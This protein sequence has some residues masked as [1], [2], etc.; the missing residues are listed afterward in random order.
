MKKAVLL[1][2]KKVD[3]VKENVA[4]S[5]Y[6][7]TCQAADGGEIFEIVSSGAFSGTAVFYKDVAA[8]EEI[9]PGRVAD[10]ATKAYLGSTTLASVK[11][12]KATA[13]ALAELEF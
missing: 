6:V 13:T 1:F 7:G 3:F 11:E 8:G 2:S 5:I 12:I 10:V 4:R 9:Y